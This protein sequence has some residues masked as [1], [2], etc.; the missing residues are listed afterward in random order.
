[1]LLTVRSL[2]KTFPGQKALDQVDLDIRVGTVHALLGENGSGKS[3]LIKVLSGYYLPDDGSDIQV[4]GHSVPAGSPSSSTLM[5]MRFVHQHLG[6]IARMTVRDNLCL[7]SD[8]GRPALAPQRSSDGRGAMEALGALGVPVGLD[9]FVGDLT[10]LQR[11]AVAIARAMDT[12]TGPL[13]LLVLDEP[14]AALNPTEVDGLFDLVHQVATQDAAVLYVSHRLEEVRQLADEATVLRDG[15][16][17]GT[18]DL[19]QTNRAELIELITGG[20]LP[21]PSIVSHDSPGRATAGRGISISGVRTAVLHDCSL[22]VA[23]GEILG[24]AGLDGSGREDLGLLLGGAV[25]GSVEVVTERGTLRGRPTVAN[26]RQIGITLALSNSHAGAYVGEMSVQE[27]L[28]LATMGDVSRRGVFSPKREREL[29]LR[30][31]KTLDV[32]PPIPSKLTA[33]L[34]GGNKQK[35]IMARALQTSPQL[36]VLVD[37]TAGVDVGARAGMYALIRELADEGLSV[38]VCSS[39]PED[40]VTLCDRVLCL[41]AGTVVA[42]LVAEQISESSI[43]ESIVWLPAVAASPAEV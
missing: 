41:A 35:V 33:D 29:A 27:N 13:R 37:P 26:L 38:L 4:D 19:A 7:T 40:L 14:T 30:W 1:V 9:R 21:E 8:L 6:L 42:E 3:T 43:L 31:M 10:P 11:S 5:G 34:S 32:R 22:E 39:D 2:S 23:E 28:S 16:R 25:P 12:D 36:L 15:R 24:V 18:V 20:A 17:S